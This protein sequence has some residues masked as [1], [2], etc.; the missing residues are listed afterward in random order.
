MIQDPSGVLQHRP[1]ERVREVFKKEGLDHPALSD[2]SSGSKTG[3]DTTTSSSKD[4]NRVRTRR[5]SK[6]SN[7][8]V[9]ETTTNNMPPQEVPRVSDL[10]VSIGPQRRNLKEDLRT[11]LIIAAFLTPFVALAN[12]ASGKLSK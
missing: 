3:K 8:P 7:A 2:K 12:Y 5:R 4:N 11:G 1:F 10:Q 6:R 9:P